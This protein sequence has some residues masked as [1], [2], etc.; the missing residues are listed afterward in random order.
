[1]TKAWAFGRAG[2]ESMP[3][4]GG[5]QTRGSILSALDEWLAVGCDAWN[6]FQQEP[7]DAESPFL[8]PPEG[9]AQRRHC[10]RPCI[11]AVSR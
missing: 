3:G 9:D 8:E 6:V 1:M 10:S 7:L 4:R 2:T 5:L 11:N